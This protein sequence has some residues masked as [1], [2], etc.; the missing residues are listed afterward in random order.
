MVLWYDASRRHTSTSPALIADEHWKPFVEAV[1]GHL[2]STGELDGAA[3][4]SLGQ[5]LGHDPAPMGD[6]PALRFSGEGDLVLDLGAGTTYAVPAP[7]VQPHLSDLG[8]RAREASMKPSAIAFDVPGVKPTPRDDERPANSASPTATPGA[9]TTPAAPQGSAGPGTARPTP[10]GEQRP[11]A[12]VGTDCQR[13]NCVAL[14]YDD[15]PIAGKSDNVLAAL[16]KTRAAATFFQLGQNLRNNAST[17]R[18][19]VSAGMEVGNHTLTHPELTKTARLDQEVR[20]QSELMRQTYG[21]APMLMRPPYGAHNAVVDRAAGKTD[22]AVIVWDVD[23]KDWKTR[24]GPLTR[25]AALV[26]ADHPGSIVLMHDIH[27]AAGQAT[28]GIVNALRARDIHPVTVTE[29]SLSDM[30]PRAGVPY[31]SATFVEPRGFECARKQLKAKPTGGTATAGDSSPST[32]NI[33]SMPVGTP[34]GVRSNQ[35]S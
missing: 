6:G 27:D 35:H 7:T 19:I 23:T 21:F 2:Q 17:G 30:A 8:V 18:S 25:T 9:E 13:V 31:C 3:A 14:T 22:Q 4:D 32:G 12:A 33:P 5:R 20:G 16:K 26:G 10:P 11:S 34:S 28:E 29:L 1:L 24:S 15:G